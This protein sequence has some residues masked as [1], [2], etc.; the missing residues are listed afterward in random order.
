MRLL[1]LLL[2]VVC[3]CVFL[4]ACA[5]LTSPAPTPVTPPAVIATW[6]ADYSLNGQISGQVFSLS[7]VFYAGDDTTKCP[8]NQHDPNNKDEVVYLIPGSCHIKPS[9]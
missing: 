1:R 4:N 6:Q 2:A 5:T 9:S 8:G 3:L 7:G